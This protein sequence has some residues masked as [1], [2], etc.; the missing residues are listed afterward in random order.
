MT[1][2]LLQGHGVFAADHTEKLPAT[3]Q[4]VRGG[5]NCEVALDGHPIQTSEGRF[6][7]PEGLREGVHTLKVNGRACEGIFVKRGQARPSGED[8]RRL[9]P[10]ISRVY[11]LE[12]R[13]RALEEKAQEKQIDWLK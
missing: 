11:D 4:I 1:L 10:V 6:T 5:E 7:L 13:L 8:F 9:L 12:E 2:Y 3:V